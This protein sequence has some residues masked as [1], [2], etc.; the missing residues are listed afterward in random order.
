M[1]RVAVVTTPAAWWW[2]EPG[3]VTRRLLAPATVR[4]ADLALEADEWRSVATTVDEVL[5]LARRAASSLSSPSVEVSVTSDLDDTCWSFVHRY[6]AEEPPAW[7]GATGTLHT[8]RAVLRM[9]RDSETAHV[10]VLDLGTARL[11]QRL[12]DQ[13]VED[14]GTVGPSSSDWW[15]TSA[16]SVWRWDNRDHVAVRAELIRQARAHATD[17]HESERVC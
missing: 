6:V 16:A 13:R 7:D 1:R 12:H 3:R 11:V 9:L 2:V 4:D 8:S 10:P 5:R 14:R 17:D 15:R